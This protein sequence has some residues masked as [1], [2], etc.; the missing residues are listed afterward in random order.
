MR[1]QEER[2]VLENLGLTKLCAKKYEKNGFIVWDDL[3]SLGTIGLIKAAMTFQ[4][5]KGTA[6]STYACRCMEN[7]IK[8][9]IN[10]EKRHQGVLSLD[11]SIQA[12][13]EGKIVL[14]DTIETPLSDFTQQ[15]EER[16]TVENAIEFALNKLS[17]KKRLAVLYY[18]AGK[19]Q[20][21]ISEHIGFSQSYVSRVWLKFL[22]EYRQ[23]SSKEE[24]LEE[25]KIKVSLKEIQSETSPDFTIESK[26]K[27]IWITI[28]SSIECLE[29]IAS[30][31]QEMN[32]FDFW[33]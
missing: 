27:R 22:R 4:E 23:S 16:K 18:I 10:R 5:S 25:C 21:W 11:K 32:E 24:N 2:V 26:G 6:F 7:E 9:A 1:E 20:E 33:I 19:K 29:N 3:I 8:M 31:I 14:L 15:D 30:I 28:F 12:D 17:G 13:E